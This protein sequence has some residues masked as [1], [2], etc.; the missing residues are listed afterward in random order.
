MNSDALVRQLKIAL[1]TGEQNTIKDWFDGFLVK[2]TVV[3]TNVYRAG[4]G[5]FIYYYDG[6]IEK[7]IFFRDD[8]EGKFYCNVQFYWNHLV[9]HYYL[10]SNSIEEITKIL[11]DNAFGIDIKTPKRILNN[12]PVIMGNAL[13]DYY[14]L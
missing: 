6:D 11:V 13:K 9:F 5:E 3:E 2:L 10:N 1:I 12:A 4:S 7:I 8:R 14:D